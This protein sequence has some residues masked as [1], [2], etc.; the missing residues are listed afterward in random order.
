MKRKSTERTPRAT[1]RAR[2]NAEQAFE[3]TNSI[4]EQAKPYRLATAKMPIQALSC[5]WSITPNRRV[6]QAHMQDLCQ[7]FQN[8]KLARASRENYILVQCSAQAIQRMTDAGSGSQCDTLLSFQNWLDIND[9]KAEVMAGQHRLEALR[10]Y[11]K[12]TGS[13]PEELWWVCEF[14]NRG[15]YLYDSSI[16][17]PNSISDTLPVE[18]N[19]KLRLNRQNLALPDSHGQIWMQLVVASECDSNLFSKKH[20]KAVVEKS[21]LDILCLSSDIRFPTSRLVTLW[22]NDRWNPIITRLCETVIGREIF[23]ITN[24]EYLASCRIDDVSPLVLQPEYWY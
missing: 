8:G 22:R 14:Y 10:E 5:T 15:K 13:G 21:M 1:K 4:R 16:Q 11:V 18:L 9:E 19:I 17:Y 7:S 20:S 24:M 3:E 6:N 12:Q 23:N 2:R